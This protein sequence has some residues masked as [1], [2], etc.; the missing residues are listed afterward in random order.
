MRSASFSMNA[1]SSTRKHYAVFA[2]RRVQGGTDDLA[3][4]DTY[5]RRNLPFS[6][7]IRLYVWL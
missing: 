2:A 6:P 4:R 7:W 3:C 5:A 1:S